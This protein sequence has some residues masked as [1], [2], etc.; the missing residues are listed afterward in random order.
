MAALRHAVLSATDG[1]P[2]TRTPAVRGGKGAGLALLTDL[3][4]PVPPSFTLNTGVCRAYLQHDEI[5]NRIWSQIQREIAKLERATGR[6]FGDPT[7]PLLVSVR[8]GAAESMPG[9]MDTILNVGLDPTNLEGLQRWGGKRFARNTRDRFEEQWKTIR[10]HISYE[11]NFTDP[12]E[13]LGTAIVAVLESWGSERARAY[14]K[15]HGLSDNTGTA[16]TVQ[17]M[18]FG[19]VD[20]TSCTGVVFSSDVA[21]GNEGLYGE[22]LTRAQGEDVVSGVQTPL[23]IAEMK[24]WNPQV[25]EQLSSI[26]RQLADHYDDVVD[27]EFTVEKGVLFI[28]Q[29]RRAKLSPLA[30]VTRAVRDVWAKRCTKESALKR[31]SLAEIGSL[32]QPTLEVPEE[33]EIIAKGLPASPGAVV[34]MIARDA[35]TLRQIIARGEDAILVRPDTSPEDLP[36][37]MA[38]KAIVTANGGKTCHAAVVARELGLP[39]VVGT[40][41]HLGIPLTGYISV[42]GAQGVVYKGRLPLVEPTLTKEVNLFLKWHNA[43]VNPPRI[44]FERVNEQLSANQLLSDFYLTDLMARLAEGSPLEHEAVMLRTKTHRE[45]AEVFALYLLMAASGESRHFYSEADSSGATAR[46]AM[47][48]LDRTILSSS[49]DQGPSGRSKMHADVVR[50]LKDRDLEFLVT[51]TRDLVTV[52]NEGSWD[53]AFGGSKWGAIAN[54]L[55]SF[56]SGKLSATLFVDHAFDLEHNGGKLFNKNPLFMSVTNESRLKL[57][58]DIKKTVSAPAELYRRLCEY[59]S[60]SN[61]VETLWGVGK[62]KKMW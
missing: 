62:R 5:P 13:Q 35:P 61:A 29:V 10:N 38:S 50:F 59:A 45:I 36:D 12:Y 9:M 21:T 25:F 27:V 22:F 30:K 14:R 7:N 37:M 60:P 55:H 8:S 57:Q 41:P 43:K 42:D 39:A 2:E 53:G 47:A 52:F 1:T 49:Y 40:G 46:L 23:P 48:R 26:V 18:V 34:G 15:H 3:G 58:L 19:N 56:L 4:L 17:A 24:T 6:T 31:V 16:V 44:A 20:H 11:I 28:L 51:H 54:A 32:R 33:A